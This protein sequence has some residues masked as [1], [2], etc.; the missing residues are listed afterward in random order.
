MDQK[1]LIKD[2]LALEALVAHDTTLFLHV[3]RIRENAERGFYHLK[4]GDIVNPVT[5]SRYPVY[6]SVQ[7]A[8]EARERIPATGPDP[9]DQHPLFFRH[10]R[11]IGA[12]PGPGICSL[13]TIQFVPC[14]LPYWGEKREKNCLA[15][16]SFPQSPLIRDLDRDQGHRGGRLHLRRDRGGGRDRRE[17]EGIVAD[18]VFEF[19]LFPGIPAG[20]RCHVPGHPADLGDIVASARRADGLPAERAIRQRFNDRMRTVGMVEGAHDPQ[21]LGLAA[22]GAL[23]LDEVGC[24]Q[25]VV[26]DRAFVSSIP[27]GDP[28]QVCGRRGVRS[29][30]FR[31]QGLLLI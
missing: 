31:D 21:A 1:T 30:I 27:F 15:G 14:D 5:G 19:L 6:R 17:V 20:H 12:M 26:A 4:S 7:A 2:L 16:G 25:N 10:R 13:I 11:G 9:G 3:A 28:R 22:D 18:P 24:R 8:R 23:A 29:A